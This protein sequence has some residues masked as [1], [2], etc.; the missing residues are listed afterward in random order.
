MPQSDTVAASERLLHASPARTVHWQTLANGAA[1]V[2]KVFLTGGPADAEQELRCGRLAKGRDVVEHLRVDTD[3]ATGRPQL[4]TTGVAG[5]DLASCVAEQGALPAARACALLAEVATSL[6]RLH[7]LRSP[8][9]PAGLCHG[10]VKPH[11]M[12]LTPGGMLLLDFEH[13]T[14]IGSAA[15]HGTAGFRAPEAAGGAATA[16]L[17]VFALGRTLTWLLV[18]GLTDGPPQAPPLVALLT[19]LL[20]PDPAQ[21][22]TAAV[23]AAELRTLATALAGDWSES[24][25]HDWSTGQFQQPPAVAD[26][27]ARCQPWARRRRLQQRLP[28]LLVHPGAVPT[29]PA[30]LLA[31]LTMAARV[32]QRFPRHRG[33]LAWRQDLLRATTAALSDA[34]RQVHTFS[35][36]EAFADAKAWLTAA[37]R[38]LLH[39]QR[40]PGQLTFAGNGPPGLLQR[41]PLQFLR[42]LAQ[43]NADAEAELARDLGDIAAA[44]QQL[45]LR[46]AEAA[47]EALAA[48]K[49]GTAEAVSKRRDRLHRLQFYLDRIARAAGNV[50]SLAS[51]QDAAALAPLGKLV[52]TATAALRQA[53]RSEG[54][55]GAVGLRNLQLTLINL[56]EEFAPCELLP[57]ALAALSASLQEVTDQAWD[58]LAEADAQLTTVPVPVRPLQLT[59]LR[60]DGLR[61][62]EAFVDRPRGARSQLLDRIETLRLALERARETRDRLA[63]SA[64]QSLAKGHWTTGLFDMER[65]VA[66]LAPSDE[67]EGDRQKLEARLLQARQQKQ[68]VEAAVRRNVDLATRFARLLDDPQSTFQSRLELL[69]ERRDGLTFVAMHVPADRADLY[70]RDL[71][72]IE[73]QMAL[74][75]AGLAEHELDRTT[76]P[77]ARLRLVQHTLDQL[78]AVARPTDGGEVPGRLTRLLDHWRTLAVQCQQQVERAH[79][80]QQLRARHRS[81][82][83]LVAAVAVLITGSAIAVAL[84]PWLWPTPAAAA[85]K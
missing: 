65:A 38:L 57:P 28:R 52:A 82:M 2:R 4:W 66:G 13:A 58:L 77:E 62:R 64:E 11:N 44:E 23:A 41:D 47:V 6:A 33:V 55:G 37:E 42:R 54:K 85:N 8:E 17:D 7:A 73:T 51:W 71:R 80:E 68:D 5:M 12:L 1:V 79:A 72:D 27:D 34:Q 78:T 19:E 50:D 40:L 32:L 74:E 69:E 3:A 70:R 43:Q 29:E 9:L 10:D 48:Q 83:L 26:D 25:L 67:P 24:V 36:R 22:P 61:V 16:A 30:S 20:H 56:G 21:R 84:R 53:S 39:A 63:Q 14:P 60:L 31:A 75:R 81:R 15:G 45:D 59:L 18:G 49:G 46:A 35:R 76:A